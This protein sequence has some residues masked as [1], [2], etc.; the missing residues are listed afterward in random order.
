MA[1][2]A[3]KTDKPKKT[4]NELGEL[5]Y[6]SNWVFKSFKQVEP[7]FSS[8]VAREIHWFHWFVIIKPEKYSQNWEVLRTLLWASGRVLP[9]LSQNW[10]PF[11]TDYIT[12]KSNEMGQPDSNFLKP[13]LNCTLAACYTQFRKKTDFMKI[14]YTVKH[15]SYG[16]RADLWSKLPKFV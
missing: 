9:I 5:K 13:S 6:S 12:A 1:K 3:E 16:E 14:S 4:V 15:Q 2:M 7:F 10:E 11:L 8:L